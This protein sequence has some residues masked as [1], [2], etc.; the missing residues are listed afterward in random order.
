MITLGGTE[1]VKVIVSGCNGIMGNYVVNVVAEQEDMEVVAGVDVNTESDYKFPV[2]SSFESCN[3][4]A[5]VIIDFS[6]FSVVGSLLDYAEITKTP[7]VICTTGLDN[8]LINRIDEMSKKV[9]LFRSGNM[10]LG[11]N[12]L[13]DLIKKAYSVLGSSFDIEIIEKHHNRKVDAPS[14]TALMLA[15]AINEEADNKFSY[16]HGREGTDVKRDKN[17]IGMHAVRG[18]TIVGD[19]SVIFAGL[20]EIIEIN[21]TALSRKVFANGSVQAARFLASQENG[22]YDMNAVL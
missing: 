7:T 10:S 6:H 15:D 4:E 14:G 5:D 22:L 19:H 3:I 20:D 11:V 12:L 9:A 16:N 8:S 18:G 13:T 1:I 21:H 2:F 17:E